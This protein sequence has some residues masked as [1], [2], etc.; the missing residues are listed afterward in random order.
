MSEIQYNSRR[1]RR[2]AEAAGL[3]AAPKDT[4]AKAAKA[5]K[6]EKARKGDKS[7]KARKAE[8]PA[9]ARKAEKA[10][11]STGAAPQTAALPAAALSAAAEAPTTAVPQAPSTIALGSLPAAVTEEK[12]GG[13]FAALK[14]RKGLMAGQA[15]IVAA[16]MVGIGAFVTLNKP[17]NLTI[18]GQS[19]VVR[20]FGQDVSDV[21]ASQGV[22]L[23]ERDQVQ[24][25]ADAPVDRDM[26]I[27][28]NRAKEINLSVDGKASTEW[29]T[30]STVETAL[31]DLGV[32]AK[33]AELS[34]DANDVLG[35][36]GES[37]QVF[38]N[39]NLTVVADG[40][41][42]KVSETVGTVNDALA[43]AKVKVDK[44]D[45]V[46]APVTSAALDGQT[47]KVLRVATETKT[48]EKKVDFKTETKNDSSLEK[49]QKKVETEG[50]QGVT[51][52]TA[53]VKTVDGVEVGRK[54]L[55]TKEKSK[56]VNE[57]VRVGTKAPAASESDSEDSGS[58]DSGSGDS[59]SGDSGG[60]MSK[61][62]IIDM[63][64]GPGT[65]WYK[66]VKC[67]SEFNP[68]AVNRTNNKYFGLFQ[69]GVPTWQG[70]GGKGHPLDA[71]PQ[72]QF[73]RAKM[74]QEQYGWSQWECAGKVGVG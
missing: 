22:E 14:N 71:S 2:E 66:I 69:F 64:G 40:K 58:S 39:K 61:Q 35:T 67:E 68:K 15:A 17:V 46:S 5:P 72:E 52:E 27:I 65:D 49:G 36:A 18:D 48:E 25:A 11:T 31:A 24:P 53:E 54:V 63:L 8:K 21:L 34:R 50:K 57:V 62:E 9:K 4:A 26:S 60:S 30:A 32:D 51:E 10:D 74:L 7:A 59:G 44:D 29:T 55:E 43:A 73:K 1:E 70:I 13:R 28:V 16:L 37:I 33:D 47:V 56:P 3:A 23:T 42:T 6:G 45:V 12:N 41:S 20:T 38:T 19:E